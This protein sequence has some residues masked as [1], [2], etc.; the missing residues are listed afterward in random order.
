MG[1]VNN[2]AEPKR[3][4]RFELLFPNDDLRLTCHTAD[5]PS[6]E[7]DTQQIDRMHEKYYVAG[8]KVTYGEVKLSFYDFV[9]NKGAAALQAWYTQIYDQGTSLMGYPNDYKKDLTLLV[10]GPDHS[11]VESWLLVGA[12][13][14]SLT[15]PGMDWKD[16]GTP[17]NIEVSLRIDQ[18]KLTLS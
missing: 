1:W 15:R 16:G 3:A 18:A 10:Y 2:L 12:W 8:S 5:I 6:I 13:P 9:D 17:R 4:N 7:V 11:L 14:K